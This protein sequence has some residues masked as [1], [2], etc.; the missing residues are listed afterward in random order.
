[1]SRTW[2]RD[3]Q[4]EV[5]GSGDDEVS[6]GVGSSS[7]HGWTLALGRCT[8]DNVGI[9]A[10]ELLGKAVVV[11]LVVLPVALRRHLDVKV[12]TV[13][14]HTATERPRDSAR[15]LPSASSRFTSGLGMKVGSLCQ[16]HPLK[17]ICHA[18][19][20]VASA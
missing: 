16:T 13:E 20:A 1:M 17:N 10:L 6:S 18:W 8:D 15:Y 9:E 4:E 19:V 7:T 3:E 11:E 12:D 2:K 5:D 14:G